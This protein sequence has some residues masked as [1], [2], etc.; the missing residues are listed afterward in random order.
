MPRTLALCLTIAAASMATAETTPKNVIILV[1]D[2]MG[3]NHV[4]AASHYRYGNEKGQ[5]YWNFLHLPITTYSSNNK[6]GYN[7]DKA[8]ASFDYFMRLPTDSAAAATAISTGHKSPNGRIATTRE[9]K[10]FPHLMDD[11]EKLGKATGALSTVRISHATPACFSIHH[12]F[13]QDEKGISRKMLSDTPLEVLMGPGHPAYDD[14]GNPVAEPDEDRYRSVGGPETWA[15]VKDGSIAPDADG[16]G[17]GDPW[18]VLETT[19]AIAALQTGETPDRVLG[20]VPVHSTLQ[21]NRSGDG[22]AAPFDV[23]LTENMPDFA[24]LL[25]AALNVLDN[26]PDG[27]YLAAEGGAVDWASHSNQGGR[28]IEE[29]IDFDKGIEAVIAWVEENSSWEETALFIT[30]DH[31]C[32]YLTGPGSD[33]AWNPIEGKGKGV[34]PGLE[35]HSGGHT[36]QLIPLFA[37]GAGVEG[38]LDMT[39]GEDER[40]GKFADNTDIP[41]LIRKLWGI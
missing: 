26:D 37:K 40:R 31:E 7:V 21:K 39:D 22:D 14:N 13:R 15:G 3:Y 30:G 6:E 27:F 4:H 18:T 20:I 32:G 28:M 23:P 10:E 29:Q 5:V 8:W 2:G 17:E 33:P 36:N 1:A 41:I 16:D 11:A 25:R 24:T 19:E 38:L 12:H 35:F 34:M 9:G